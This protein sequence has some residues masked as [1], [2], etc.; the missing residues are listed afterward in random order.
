M[1]KDHL[2]DYATNAF[3]TYA[4]AGRPSA[5]I[6]AQYYEPYRTSCGRAADIC[7]VCHTLSALYSTQ[8][9]EL[10][11][12]CLEMVYFTDANKKLRKNDITARV[13]YAARTL[14]MDVSTV[15]R[16]LKVARDLFSALRGLNVASSKP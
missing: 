12:C 9:G 13:A 4:A 10:T 16:R 1:K 8:D 3:R 2:R 7:A 11:A 15:Y 14:N 5:D 6:V